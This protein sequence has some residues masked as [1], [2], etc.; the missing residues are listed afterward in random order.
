MIVTLAC[1]QQVTLADNLTCEAS[2]ESKVAFFISVILKEWDS[3]SKCTNSNRAVNLCEKLTTPTTAG[4]D[5]RSDHGDCQFFSEVKTGGQLSRESGGLLSRENGGL[6][7]R[8]SGRI[9]SR[10]SGRILIRESGQIL[11]SE[12]C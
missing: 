6:L 9:L 10:E 3:F 8:E 2:H 7:S 5:S 11:G 4:R 1:N 12:N